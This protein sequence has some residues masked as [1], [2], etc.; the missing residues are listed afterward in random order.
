[1]HPKKLFLLL[2]IAAAV[3]AVM[4]VGISGCDLEQAGQAVQNAA[5][6]AEQQLTDP[7]SGLQ[8]AAENVNKMVPPATVVV[9]TIPFPGAKAVLG[10]LGLIS[11][12]TNIILGWRKKT[13]DTALK[14]VVKGGQSFKKSVEMDDA[15]IEKFKHAQD[16]E[17]SAATKQIVAVIKAA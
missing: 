13:S 8:Q 9:Q 16:S 17:Q 3:C 14:E 2:L 10:V 5:G 11:V 12:I 7:N 4:L 1:M 15:T 6:Q